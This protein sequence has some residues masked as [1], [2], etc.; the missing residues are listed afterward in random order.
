MAKMGF[1]MTFSMIIQVHTFKKSG[2][3]VY[4]STVKND[5]VSF[6]PNSEP[7]NTKTK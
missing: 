4:P 5:I 2:A 3:K 1:Y 7:H 6:W